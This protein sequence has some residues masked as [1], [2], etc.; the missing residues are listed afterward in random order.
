LNDACFKEFFATTTGV[1]IAWQENHS[2]AVTTHLR[3]TDAQL[4]SFQS[5]EL[6]RNLHGDPGAIPCVYLTSLGSPV[7]K[8]DEHL[9]GFP[10]NCVGFSPVHV[11][12]EADAATV[13]FKLRIVKPLFF[14]NPGIHVHL[15]LEELF[16]EHLL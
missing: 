16:R 7:L 15:L 14:R 4:F 6:V 5:E 11:G 1:R 12:D 10:Y 9:Q 13:V 8:I 2:N 3:Q